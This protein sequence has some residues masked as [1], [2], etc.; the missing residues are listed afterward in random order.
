MQ[1]YW[2]E[3]L[4]SSIYLDLAFRL[5]EGEWECELVLQIWHVK[6]CGRVKVLSSLSLSLCMCV[7]VSY[8]LWET[9]IKP[10]DYS[11]TEVWYLSL[12]RCVFFFFL[13]N[14]SSR[15]LTR[16]ICIY[17][18]AAIYGTPSFPWTVWWKWLELGS[19][20]CYQNEWTTIGISVMGC[21]DR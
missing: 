3:F 8:Q 15:A 1:C 21:Q 14:W 18:L 9:G 2:T 6:C 12:S 11:F 17:V 4:F 13:L 7:R 19:L 20:H 10:A 5:H 16:C